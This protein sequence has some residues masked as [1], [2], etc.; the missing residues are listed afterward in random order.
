MLHIYTNMALELRKRP[1]NGSSTG[2]ETLLT[3]NCLAKLLGGNQSFVAS[4]GREDSFIWI[5]SRT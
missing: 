5:F 2:H 1:D 4:I 3:S